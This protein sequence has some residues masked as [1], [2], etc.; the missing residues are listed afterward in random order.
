MATP[1]RQ[2][3]V[4]DYVANRL[5]AVAERAVSR[6]AEN[7]DGLAAAI[8]DALHVRNRVHH[9]FAKRCRQMPAQIC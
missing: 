9:R 2:L 3:L 4:S 1:A 8:A 5:D 7:D 6:A